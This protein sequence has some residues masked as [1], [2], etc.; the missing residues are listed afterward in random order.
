MTAGRATHYP[1]GARMK[2]FALHGEVGR[3]SAGNNVL[4]GAQGKPSQREDGFS[5][6]IRVPANARAVQEVRRA[7][8]ELGLPPPL[9]EDARLLV[10]EL[11]TNSIRHAGLG[12]DDWILVRASWSGTKLWVEVMDRNGAEPPP[13]TRATRPAPEAESG[14]GLYLVER[15]AARWGRGRGR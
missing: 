10:S 7:L 4:M 8:G 3:D 5:Q 15:L 13:V 14:W 1:D 11:V 9:L 2:S 12:R 6:E